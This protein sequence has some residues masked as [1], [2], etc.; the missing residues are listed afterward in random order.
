MTLKDKYC[1]DAQGKFWYLKISDFKE[2]IKEL[3]EENEKLRKQLIIDFKTSL[4]V[5]SAKRFINSRFEMSNERK[6][7]LAGKQLSQDELGEELI[8]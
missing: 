8:K 4:S 7:K 6:D 3:K 2:F 5:E 1:Y